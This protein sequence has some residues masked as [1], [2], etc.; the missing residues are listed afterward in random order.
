MNDQYYPG[1]E[2]KKQSTGNQE[3]ERE[4]TEKEWQTAKAQLAELRKSHTE[5]GKKI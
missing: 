4:I 2:D 5:N 1:K 3:Y